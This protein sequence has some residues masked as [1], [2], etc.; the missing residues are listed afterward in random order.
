MWWIL[1]DP[2]VKT[3]DRAVDSAQLAEGLPR[4]HTALGPDP[5]E[6]TPGVW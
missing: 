2:M 3:R 6:H 4:M 5:A 1:R